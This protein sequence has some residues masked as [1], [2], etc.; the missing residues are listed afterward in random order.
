MSFLRERYRER[1]QSNRRES[2]RSNEKFFGILRISVGSVFFLTEKHRKPGTKIPG[3]KGF[4]NRRKM[5][6]ILDLNSGRSAFD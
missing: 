2:L 1:S 4:L 6:A 3:K 5:E